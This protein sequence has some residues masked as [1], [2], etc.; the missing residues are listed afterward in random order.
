VK[1]IVDSAV[2]V[3]AGDQYHMGRLTITGLDL[4]GEAEMKRIWG[5]PEGK[6]FNPEYPDNF[7]K[8]VRSEGMFDNL[9]DTKADVKLNQKDHIADVTL[10]FKG[11]PPKPDRPG[12]WP[13][14]NF[15]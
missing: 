3:E 13:G 8:G 4:N 15:R 7:L 12:G 9:G 1:H 6:P 2:R 11:A 5:M 14:A 10:N